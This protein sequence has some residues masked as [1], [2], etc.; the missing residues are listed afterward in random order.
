MLAHWR[1]KTKV[2]M[3]QTV[4]FRTLS[5]ALLI[6]HSANSQ[7][8][9]TTVVG[10]IPGITAVTDGCVADSDTFP[11]YVT[12]KSAKA[13]DEGFYGWI[14]Y[15]HVADSDSPLDHDWHDFNFYV[16]LDPPFNGTLNSAANYTNQNSYM[17]YP[18]P[19]NLNQKPWQSFSYEWLSHPNEPLMEV[20]WDSS[21]VPQRF[22]ASA[23]DRVWFKGRYIWD[24]GH[25]DPDP[26]QKTIA[27]GAGYH[28]EMHPPRAI[29]VTR[30]EP[31]Q[32]PGDSGYSLTT[33]TYI[34]VNG[35]S[36]LKDLSND[37]ASVVSA[38][39]LDV[40]VAMEDYNFEID[41]PARPASVSG[42]PTYSVV[43]LPFGGP[44]PILGY[45]P[46]KQKVTVKYPLNLGDPNPN[47]RFGAVIAAGWRQ[48]SGIRFRTVKVGVGKIEI[49]NQHNPLCQSNWEL[50]VAVNGD[51]RKIKGTAGL[52]VGSVIDVEKEWNVVIQDD[53]SSRIYVE[54]V[55]WVNVFDSTFGSPDDLRRLIGE[56]T[57]IEQLGGLVEDLAGTKGKIGRVFKHFT[58]ADLRS[59]AACTDGHSGGCMTVPSEGTEEIDGDL[60]DPSFASTGG[61]YVIKSLVVNF[62]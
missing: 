44:A 41:L 34:Y 12:V 61:D 42:D 54:A 32:F 39:S 40:P 49:D 57:Q 24:C 38:P 20:E 60:G 11:H 19:A 15:S 30:L 2:R 45:N 22:W 23:G 33:K 29:A 43:E 27:N 4:C 48:P 47:L 52:C 55:G 37:P 51:W 18:G 21:H 3:V 35:N 53:P 25:A 59:F 62:P 28:T 36:G 50:W 56:P 13:P 7:I 8:L 10:Q 14:R 9:G 46:T 26:T 31:Y 17:E 1:S 58:L 16:S 5:I 6:T